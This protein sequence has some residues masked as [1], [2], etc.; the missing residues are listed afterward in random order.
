[1]I[2]KRSTGYVSQNQE[3]AQPVHYAIRLTLPLESF[4]TVW[5]LFTTV[6]CVCPERTLNFPSHPFLI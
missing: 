3:E 1:M 4:L 2:G 5:Y 6:L